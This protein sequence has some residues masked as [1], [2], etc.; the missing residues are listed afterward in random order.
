MPSKGDREAE[1]SSLLLFT[2]TLRGGGG[3]GGGE[4]VSVGAEEDFLCT[5]EETIDENVQE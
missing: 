3:G 2:P 4:G 5:P 1:W